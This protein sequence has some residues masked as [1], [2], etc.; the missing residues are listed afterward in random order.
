MPINSFM[1]ATG[2]ENSNPTIGHGS[3]RRDQMEECGHYR[4]WRTDFA[5]VKQLGIRYLRYGVPLH[6][7][8]LGP[9]RYDWSFADETFAELQRLQLVPIADLCHFGVPDWIGN[10]QNPDFGDLFARY[11]TDFATRFPWVKYYTPVNE[12]Y[13]CARFS[14]L[15]GWWNEQLR[16][17]RGFVTALKNLVRAN[18]LAMHA[19]LKVN[20]DAVFIQ[21]ESSEYFHASSPEALAVADVRNARRFLS[22]DFNYGRALE[23]AML[24]YVLDNGMTREEIDFFLNQDLRRHCILGSDYYRSNEHH[25]AADAS[26]RPANELLGYG[27][28]VREYFHRYG[29][30]LMHT[31]TNRDEG[32][33]GHEA[34][35]W[36]Y[37]EWALVR[38]LCRDGVNVLGFTWYSLTDQVDWDIELREK[39]GKVNPR[40][41]FDLERRI[42]PVGEAYRRLVATWRNG[43]PC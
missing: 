40:G 23:P 33:R 7:S 16:T 12:M 18:V 34:V 9:G 27:M 19:I 10:F 42:R 38:G 14:G 3:I 24:E 37:K 36:L 22:L 4:H 17:D 21:S 20:P 5:L 43:P 31:E 39:R 29:L 25:I 1:F 41:L 30:P 11:A 35:D 26:T 15:Q 28:I 32:P 2:I 13:V 8:F 6:R